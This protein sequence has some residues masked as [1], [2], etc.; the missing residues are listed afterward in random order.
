MILLELLAAIARAHAEQ[1]HP[2]V[3][4]PDLHDWHE[5]VRGGEIWLENVTTF[6][7]NYWLQG[8]WV[9]DDRAGWA[10]WLGVYDRCPVGEDPWEFP[11]CRLD[12]PLPNAD[13]SIWM[14]DDPATV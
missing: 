5:V 14:S 8:W 1:H 12:S 2:K 4:D 7:F 11:Y 3:L 10:W 6:E 13:F 9:L